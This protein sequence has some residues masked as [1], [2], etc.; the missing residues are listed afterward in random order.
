M[1]VVLAGLPSLILGRPTLTPLAQGII[2]RQ[3]SLIGYRSQMP[4]RACGLCCR[5][6]PGA[7]NGGLLRRLRAARFRPRFLLVVLG[8]AFM[9]EPL[10]R[11]S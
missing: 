6:H 11:F 4:A 10:G 2:G 8:V 9:A 3:C 1:P 5:A 7:G